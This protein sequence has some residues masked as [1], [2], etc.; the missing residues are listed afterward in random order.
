MPSVKLCTRDQ[1]P[2]K[3]FP[4]RESVDYSSLKHPENKKSLR[5]VLHLSNHVLG[6]RALEIVPGHRNSGLCLTKTACIYYLT[7]AVYQG[8]RD[9]DI[10]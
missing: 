6:S 1:G 5:E 7:Q 10:I 2:Q 4:N 8:S 9:L 3:T